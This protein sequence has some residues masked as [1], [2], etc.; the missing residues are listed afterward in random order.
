M[1]QHTSQASRARGGESIRAE[2]LALCTLLVLFQLACSGFGLPG[3][4]RASEEELQAYAIAVAPLPADPAAAESRLESFV[5]RWPKGALAGDALNQLAELALERGDTDAAASWFYRLLQSDPRG[6]RADAT[7]L[8][9]A[10]LEVGR[11]NPDSARALLAKL[12]YSRLPPAERVDAYALQADLAQDPGEE[13]R[14]LAALRAERADNQLAT[15][16]LDARIDDRIASLDDAALERASTRL[17]KQPPA[18]RVQLAIAERAIAR[19][20]T[21]QAEKALERAAE[22]GLREVDQGRR[23]AL[24]RQL[25]LR[26]TAERPDHLPS[27]ETVAARARPRTQGANGT[28]G[29]VLPLSGP[30]AGY[31]E[32][33]LRGILLAAGIFEADPSG[34]RPLAGQE[35]LA[36]NRW[37]YSDAPV[38]PRG[39]RLQIRDTAGEPAR[40]A[41]AVQELAEDPTVVAVIGPLLAN[42]FEAAAA[43][44]QEARLPLIAL[45]SRTEI[46][47]GRDH[48]FRIRTTPEDEVRFLVDYAFEQRGARRFAVLY[49]QDGYGRGMRDRFW[50]RVEER[51]GHVVGA[52]SYDPAATDFAEPIRQMIGYVLLTADE[53]EALKERKEVLRRARR[54]PPEEAAVVREEAYAVLGPEGDPLPPIV[55]FDALFIPDAHDKVVL[56]APQLAFHEIEDVTLL[57]TAGWNHPD[58]VRIARSHVAGGVIA[59]SFHPESR[60]P[61]V[62]DFV[63]E[64]TDTFGSVPD[65]FGAQA[66]DAT[67]LVLSQLAAAGMPG[68]EA[69]EDIREDIRE[70]VLSVQAYPGASGVISFLPDGNASKRPFLLGVRG[71]EIVSLD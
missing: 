24:E 12:R 39:L 65:A 18:G 53:K 70:G 37:S 60:F 22:I 54:L 15:A 19:G 61:F 69:L 5:A 2:L 28:L 59:A 11:G 68:E 42:E 9:L 20:D 31:G 17:P 26:T 33:S 46:P 45:S 4:P 29:V 48:V 14:W 32:E 62:A 8:R 13:L 64:Y 44:A 67:N 3:K 63:T 27:F 40:A 58:L 36:A 56:I 1:I 52:G 7:R 35:E 10:R 23:V 38:A 41:R 34:P 49:P 66:F 16:E 50:Q 43:A 6:V 21:K 55:D 71:G 25:A 57:G 30:F 47:R 51:G